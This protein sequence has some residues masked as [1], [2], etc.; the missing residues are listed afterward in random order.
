MRPSRQLCPIYCKNRQE[1]AM[2]WLH[3]AFH[4]FEYVFLTV[5]YSVFLAAA[6][7]NPASALVWVVCT[8]TNFSCLC[9]D[10]SQ[11][12]YSS[13]ALSHTFAISAANNAHFPPTIDSKAYVTDVQSSHGGR[14]VADFQDGFEL[15]RYFQ[16]WKCKVVG[17]IFESKARISEGN[18]GPDKASAPSSLL[19]WEPAC[20]SLPKPPCWLFRVPLCSLHT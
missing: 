13:L 7:S 6:D 10:S 15:Q 5:N 2:C 19:W 18:T 11:T 12:L 3:I 8:L 20:C 17:N 16:L 9:S 14:L 1:P 4:K